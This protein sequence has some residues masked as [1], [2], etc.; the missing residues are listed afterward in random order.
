MFKW[1]IWR[2]CAHLCGMLRQ[3]SSF[4]TPLYCADSGG[5]MVPFPQQQNV[6]KL[7]SAQTAFRNM[8]VSWIKSHLGFFYFFLQIGARCRG[9]AANK[10]AATV[11]RFHARVSPN[12]WGILI[13]HF[14]LI[15]LWIPKKNPLSTPS[16]QLVNQLKRRKKKKQ[17]TVI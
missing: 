11:L 6:T 1:F 15:C 13:L 4:N 17:V 10:S 5:A 14:V 8:T 16:V 9:C 7:R 12:F 2:G 3:M